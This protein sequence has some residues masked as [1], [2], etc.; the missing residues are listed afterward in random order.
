M[1]PGTAILALLGAAL[2]GTVP[3]CNADLSDGPVPP[4]GD[5]PIRDDG[6]GVATGSDRTLLFYY[7]P[8]KLIPAELVLHSIAAFTGHDFGAWDPT[9]PEPTSDAFNDA[10]NGEGTFYRHCRQLGGCL[11][12]RIPLGRTGFVN[13]AYVLQLERAVVEACDDRSALGM[14]PG[15]TSPDESTS[16]IDVVRHQYL[17]AFGVEPDDTDVEISQAYFESHLASPEQEDVSPL[18]SAGRGHCRAL[19]TTNRFLFY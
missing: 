16:V 14:F 2:L 5:D 6:A 18:E 17:G 7:G 8:M 12:H 15:G 10:G 13:T 3:A 9:A 19:L 4:G 11:E 1:R